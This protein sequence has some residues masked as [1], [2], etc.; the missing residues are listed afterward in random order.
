[1]DVHLSKVM[2][3]VAIHTDTGENKKE[4]RQKE[5]GDARVSAREKVSWQRGISPSFATYKE[6]PCRVVHSPELLQHLFTT[7]H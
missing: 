4:G 5:E 1:M 3:L 7:H 6:L 2:R